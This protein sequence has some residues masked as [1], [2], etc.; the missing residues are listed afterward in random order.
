MPHQ[1]AGRVFDIDLDHPI[2]RQLALH[3]LEKIPRNRP[4]FEMVTVGEPLDPAA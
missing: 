4:T 1:D 3:I 2:T